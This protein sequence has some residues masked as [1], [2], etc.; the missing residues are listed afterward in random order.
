M[1]KYIGIAIALLWLVG[2][3]HAV[4]PPELT[5][6]EPQL[7]TGCLQLGVL[8]ETADAANPFPIIATRRMVDQVKE[9]ARHL[10]ATHIVWLHKTDIAATAEVF[11][12]RLFPP[13]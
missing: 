4:E 8:T 9:R 5:E 2:C 1:L 7:V 11:N 13:D 6:T 12:C 3:A 10:G